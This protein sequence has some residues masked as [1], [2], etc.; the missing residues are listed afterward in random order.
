MPRPCRRRSVPGWRPS[1]ALH[2]AHGASVPVSFPYSQRR[3]LLEAQ[4]RQ[5]LATPRAPR[6]ALLRR[7]NL[8]KAHLHRLALAAHGEG[9]TVSDANN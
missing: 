3:L 8:G 7:V 4:V 9:V 5:R 6:L 1:C 2:P